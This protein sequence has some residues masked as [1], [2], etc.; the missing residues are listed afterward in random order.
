MDVLALV[1][2][3]CIP[4]LAYVAFYTGWNNIVRGWLYAV[5][6][7]GVIIDR[8]GSV[9]HRHNFM[10]HSGQLAQCSHGTS[11]SSVVLIAWVRTLA[12]C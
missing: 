7:R 11:L 10:S 12:L 8:E 2:G 9:Y 4:A 1:S 5:G 3:P 6:C